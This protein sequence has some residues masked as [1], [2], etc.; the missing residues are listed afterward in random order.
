MHWHGLILPNVMDGAAHVTQDPIQKG[1]VYH[2]EFT[3]V[4]Y[5]TYLYH[6]HDHVDRQQALGLYGALIIDPAAR[7]PSVEANYDYAVLLQEWLKRE[8][9]TFPAMPM[10]GGQPNFFTINGR[11]YPATETIFMRAGETLKV[12]FIGS[13]NGF[14]HPMHI[15]GGPFEVVAVDGQTLQPSARYQADTINVGPVAAD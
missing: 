7:D 11:A 6:S 9:L 5:G 14:I 13:N 10:D 8:G 3:P 4:Q 1:G 2:Y 15:H 12:R